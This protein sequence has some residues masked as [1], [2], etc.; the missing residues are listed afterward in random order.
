M[1]TKLTD[2]LAYHIQKFWRSPAFQTLLTDELNLSYIKNIRELV[3][4]FEVEQAKPV[5]CDSE[6]DFD[7]F[8]CETDVSLELSNTESDDSSDELS[9]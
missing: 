6:C 7:D 5:D 3:A 9:E 4:S 8:A 1:E 2:K